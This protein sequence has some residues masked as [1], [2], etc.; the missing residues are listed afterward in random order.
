MASFLQI[1]RYAYEEPYHLQL[2]FRLS[3]GSLVGDAEIY[4]D[5]QRVEE[6]GCALSD[7]PKHQ[8]HVYLWEVGSERAEDR[9]A[10][11]MRLRCFLTDS[12]G[13]CALHIRFNNNRPL[14]EKEIF[15][16]CIPAEPAALNRLGA[17]LLTFARLEHE[18][19]LWTPEDVT[20][21]RTRFEAEGWRR[22]NVL[23]L[24]LQHFPHA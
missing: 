9:W 19:L 5:A 16:F 1:D 10:Y 14:P 24:P 21:F 20:L 8:D 18:V 4:V 17:G 23:M 12:T 15:E 7:F 6:W 2:R 22:E 3:N 13:H 11:Y